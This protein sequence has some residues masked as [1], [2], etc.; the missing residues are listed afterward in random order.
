MYLGHYGAAC[1]TPGELRNSF[2]VVHTNDINSVNIYFCSCSGSGSHSRIQLLRAS[3]LPSSVDIP[4]SAFTFDVMDSFHLLTLQGK[5]SAYDY[6]LSISHKSDNI[7]TSNQKVCSFRCGNLK[8]NL[9]F[10]TSGISVSLR[11]I[12]IR[13]SDLATHQITQAHWSWPR[14]R[15]C[16]CH[17][18]WRMCH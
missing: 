9:P 2:V 8:L 17:C 7:G 12:L 14:S 16:C 5:T 15:W 11:S 10:L 18:G 6:Y 13:C 4:R 3:W 1:P